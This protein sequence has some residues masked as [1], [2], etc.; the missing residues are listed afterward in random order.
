M[1]ITAKVQVSP[2]QMGVA[3]WEMPSDEQV[4]FF[5]AIGKACEDMEAF[6]HQMSFVITDP[7]L[8]PKART[9]MMLIGKSVSERV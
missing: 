9:L 1:E 4:E 8:T 6:S 5:N 2:A 3:F 7:D